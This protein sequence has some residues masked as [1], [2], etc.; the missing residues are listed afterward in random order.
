MVAACIKLV[1]F[2]NVRW[3]D[4]ESMK[5]SPSITLSQLRAILHSW[6]RFW[7]NTGYFWP[8]EPLSIRPHDWKYLVF[9]PKRNQV[10]RV[11]LSCEKVILG[12]VFIGSG[13]SHLTFSKITNFVHAATTEFKFYVI[14]K[15]AIAF[16]Y[17]AYY[18]TVHKTSK[19]SRLRR[20]NSLER[21]RSARIA[22]APGK[23][24]AERF[25][26]LDEM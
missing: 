21:A 18:C 16:L 15:W 10:C 22:S 26:C 11:V 5:T 1:I 20:G 25:S 19:L 4:P 13:S 12:K 24:N 8:T 23:K 3:D 2:E 7:W 14:M 17:K 9:L 6:F